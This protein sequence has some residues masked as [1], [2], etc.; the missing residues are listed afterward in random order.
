MGALQL[1]IC[2]RI[3]PGKA[4][5]ELHDESHY[6]LAQLLLDADLARGSANELVGRGITRVLFPHGLGHSLGIVTHD[7]GMKP[8]PPRS[9]NKFLRNTSTIEVGQVF[10]IEPGLYIIDALVGP[11]RLGDRASLVNWGALDEVKPY[12][13]IRI[14][15][16][17]LVEANGIR[18]LTREAYL[19]QPADPR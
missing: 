19:A 9:E 18:N 15:D 4:Y 12:G 1:A 17:V 11:V 3:K 5:E 7:V 10:T 13:G 6:L 2:A 16:N 8:R 14:E